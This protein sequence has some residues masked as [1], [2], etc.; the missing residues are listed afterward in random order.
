MGTNKRYGDAIDREVAGRAHRAA[1]AVPDH[2]HPRRVLR[3]WTPPW[4]PI[5]ISR[6]EWIVMRDDKRIPVAVIR[7]LRLGPRQETFFRVVTWAEES[8]ER[9]LVGYFPTLAEADRM[10]LFKPKNPQMPRRPG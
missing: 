1:A 4:P 5:Q 7:R 2:D 9:E 3:D 6:D 10:V 8:A